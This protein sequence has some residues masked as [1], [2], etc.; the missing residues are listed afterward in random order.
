MRVFY[1][2]LSVLFIGVG[3][4]F[5]TNN[6][7]FLR[8][9]GGL[10]QVRMSGFEASGFEL[11]A[12]GVVVREFEADEVV[13]FED[14]DEFKQARVKLFKNGVT[15]ALNT[16]LAVLK[17]EVLEGFEK[18]AYT[19]SKNIEFNSTHAIFE[20]DEERLTADAEFE[21]R[22]NSQVIYAKK[23][24]YEGKNG[25]LKA[26]GVRSIGYTK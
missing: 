2:A 6:S 20:L 21:L 11:D 4:V 14:R 17:D 22:Q 8:L 5:L 24:V 15:H 7:P 13:R 26:S 23:G 16:S 3:F 1:L 25:T 19:N 18:V 12:Q 9:F 10:S